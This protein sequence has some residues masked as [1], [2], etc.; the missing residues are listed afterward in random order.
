[1]RRRDLI[2]LS[3]SIAAAMLL[4]PVAARAQQPAGLRH[5]GLLMAQNETN[6]EVQGWVAVLREG[7][8]KLGWVEGRNIHFQF[9]WTGSNADLMRRGAEELIALQPDL[10]VTSSS[11]TTAI[12]LQLT[13]TIPIVFT[14]S[15][16][17]VGRD[18]SLRFASGW[19]RDRRGSSRLCW[20]DN[21]IC[22]S[23]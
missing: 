10:I 8:E 9:R 13:R 20:A 12:L 6:A 21:W 18:L 11:P 23:A 16:D 2:T 7:L 15:V 19:Q 5:I 17:P 3:G 14:N 1:M 4:R 22:C